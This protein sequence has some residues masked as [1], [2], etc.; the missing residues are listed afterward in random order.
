MAQYFCK[1]SWSWFRLKGYWSFISAFSSKIIR[2][3]MYMIKMY[4]IKSQ[5]R[6]LIHDDRLLA[7]I[8]KNKDPW[9]DHPV[10]NDSGS[11]SNFFILN[12]D[13]DRLQ[14]YWANE[15]FIRPS[16]VSVIYQMIA[17]IWMGGFVDKVS[18]NL[19]T[20]WKKLTNDWTIAHDCC[21]LW[22]SWHDQA[23]N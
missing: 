10:K 2:H 20:G 12:W 11:G 7:M 14:K 21:Q 18:S 15:I 3:I 8:P 17:C 5:S 19:T 6:N 16:L 1:R 9:Q 13:R 23:D 4:I 22:A